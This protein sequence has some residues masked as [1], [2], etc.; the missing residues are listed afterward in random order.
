MTRIIRRWRKAT[1]NYAE[2]KAVAYDWNMSKY[3]ADKGLMAAYGRDVAP[4]YASNWG[5]RGP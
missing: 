1:K 4:E 5:R 3:F 2:D